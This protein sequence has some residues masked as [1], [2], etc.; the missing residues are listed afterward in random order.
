M[1]T[2]H[3]RPEVEMSPFSACAMHAVIETVHL[4]WNWLWGRYHVTQ[5]VF[6]V[7]Y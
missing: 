5:N 1:V 3:F 4:L 6:L 2:S 7:D